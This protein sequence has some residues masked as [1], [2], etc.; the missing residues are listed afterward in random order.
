LNDSY[1]QGIE[2]A[3]GTGVIYCEKK[4]EITSMRK[5]ERRKNLKQ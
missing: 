4:K 1:A 3:K 2:L 5:D